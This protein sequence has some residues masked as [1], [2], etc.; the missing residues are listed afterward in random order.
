MAACI[1]RVLCVCAPCVRVC[2][3]GETVGQYQAFGSTQAWPALA[4]AATCN[5]AAARRR[6]L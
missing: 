6:F 4:A 2:G 1:V 5:S 3:G